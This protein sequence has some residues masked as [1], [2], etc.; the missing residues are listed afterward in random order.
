MMRQSPPNPIFPV[1]V[2]VS[3]DDARIPHALTEVAAEAE[4]GKIKKAKAANAKTKAEP[5][6]VRNVMH[7]LYPHRLAIPIRF[8][9][10]VFPFF[11]YLL[12]RGAFHMLFICLSGLQPIF[13]MLACRALLWHIIA[14]QAF[15]CADEHVFDP[16]RLSRIG[17]YFDIEFEL[18]VESLPV[19]FAIN[20][21]EKACIA[22]FEAIIAQKP[23]IDFHLASILIMPSSVLQFDLAILA[24]RLIVDDR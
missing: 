5:M 14:V 24:R 9:T 12:L 21:D 8:S 18:A 13:A 19:F 22:D 2:Y 17:N 4:C 6:E 11:P 20:I 1:R 16:V 10:S 15:L 23:L 7:Q 3:D